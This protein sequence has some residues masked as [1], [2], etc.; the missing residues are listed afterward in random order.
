MNSLTPNP[1]KEYYIAY[2]DIL[3]YKEFFKQQPEKASEF[4]HA[5]HDAVN[6]TNNHTA[7]ANQSPIMSQIGQIEIQTKIFSDNILLCMEALEDKDPKEQIRIIAFLKII[8]D[9]QRGFV[10][11]YGLFVRGGIVK[12]TLSFN[13]EY[14]FGQGLIDAVDIEGTALFPRIIIDNSIVSLLLNNQ[15]YTQE[16]L[17]KAIQTEQRLNQNKEVSAE[18]QALYSRIS[19]QYK[20]YSIQ[21]QLLARLLIQWQDNTWVLCYLNNLDN[22]STSITKEDALQMIKGISPSDY[23][24]AASPS[25]D[26]DSILLQHKQI[27]EEQLRK[28]GNNQ[29]IP[30]GDIKAAEQREKIL[31]K[32]IWTMTY[33]NEMCIRYQKPEYTILTK[34]NCDTRF[35]KMKIDVLESEDQTSGTS[36]T[37]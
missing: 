22:I 35:V 17:D 8:A 21:M 18:E 29:D 1:I 19:L 28:Y 10:T 7:I 15:Y 20:M 27:V 33:H 24:L 16:E 34:C 6:R 23:Q 11:E 2:F 9:I 5:I 37:H 13:E 32:Y 30:T 31:R 12:G 4:L 26:F 3:G 25:K 36:A 14:V